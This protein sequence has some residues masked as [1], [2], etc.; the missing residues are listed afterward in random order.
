MSSRAS[1]TSA[2]LQKV[3]ISHPMM[4]YP[5]THEA[6]RERHTFCGFGDGEA[7]ASVHLLGGPRQALHL[8]VEGVRRCRA[9]DT[10]WYVVLFTSVQSWYLYHAKS[11]RMRK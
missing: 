6:R 4:N 5:H 9:S 7:V 3:G 11:A 10:Q 8:A 2:T 1:S